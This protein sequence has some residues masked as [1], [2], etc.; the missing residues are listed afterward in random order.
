MNRQCEIVQDLL[1]LYVDD[2]CSP[3]SREMIA[4]H[5]STCAECAGMLK[6][7]KNTEIETELITEKN[8]VLKKQS[9]VFKRKSALAGL[10]IGMAMMIP[11]IVV[12]I[13]T[14]ASG[15]SAEPL[16]IV[17]AALLLGASLIVAPLVFPRNKFLWTVG[18]GTIFLLILLAVI[19]VFNGGRWFFVAASAILFGLSVVI[20]PIVVN[21]KAVRSHLRNNKALIVMGAST[22]LYIIM[23]LCIGFTTGS[24][25]FAFRGFWISA[26]MLVLIWLYF[27]II[28]Y[29]K[30]NGLVK[31]GILCII[32]GA[33]IFA[34]NTILGAIMGYNLGWP[35]M[36]LTTWNAFTVDGNVKWLCLLA[37]GAIG[38]I[39]IIIGLIKGGIKK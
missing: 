39:L 25:S 22:I 4:E 7:L 18:L 14:L 29:L 16:F 15:S 36:N 27:V 32:T 9:K 1:P 21:H 11:V 26:V 28:R 33:F 24:S 35:A 3:A 2:I 10:I 23:M 19:A 5:L 34:I 37:G 13:V 12:F 20:G 17:L 38:I 6:S 30:T 8:D 31:A